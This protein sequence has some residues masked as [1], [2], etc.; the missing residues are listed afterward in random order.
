MA[1]PDQ[2][3]VAGASTRFQPGN[4]G[5]PKGARNKL[6]EAFVTALLNDFQTGGIAAIETVRRDDPSTYVRVIAGLLP[7]ELTAED[8]E[9]LFQGITV[10]FVRPEKK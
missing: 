10:S 2:L 9:P 1:N 5:R 6:G 4:P 8:G 3:K 7:K